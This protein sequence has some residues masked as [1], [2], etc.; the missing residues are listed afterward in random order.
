MEKIEYKEKAIEEISVRVKEILELLGEDVNR[1]GLRETPTRVAKALY[2]M[3]SGLRTEPP[4]IKVFKLSETGDVEYEE[5]QLIVAKDVGFSSLCEHHLLP[6][7]GKVH[8][9]YVVGKGGKVAGFS[10]L[11]RITNYYASRPQIQERLV[12]QIA[13]ALMNSDVEPKGVLVIGSGVHMCS[14]VRGVKDREANLVS[15]A[16][17]GVLKTNRSLRNQAM[18]LIES[19]TKQNLL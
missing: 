14:F 4:E 8:I 1:E 12:S 10:K 19:S 2:E 11:I 16:T 18:R 15:I 13:D 3:T 6:F 5:D 17:R 9:A 7:I